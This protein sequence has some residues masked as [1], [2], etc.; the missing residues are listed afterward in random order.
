MP[1]AN[2]ENNLG[3]NNNLNNSNINSIKVHKLNE[4][5]A[6]PNINLKETKLDRK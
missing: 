5:N 4:V 3:Q 6:G 1:N 2:N